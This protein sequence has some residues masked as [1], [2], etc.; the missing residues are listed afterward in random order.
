MKSRLIKIAIIIIHHLQ[1]YIQISIIRT[2][3]TQNLDTIKLKLR[4]KFSKFRIRLSE[5]KTLIRGTE[6]TTDKVISKSIISIPINSHIPD[7]IFTIDLIPFQ[8]VRPRPIVLLTKGYTLQI[9]LQFGCQHDARHDHGQEQD[10]GVHDARRGGVLARRTTRAAKAHCCRT[11]AA[12]QGAHRHDDTHAAKAKKKDGLQN[13][14]ICYLLYLICDSSCLKGHVT[15]IE[16]M[17]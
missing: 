5:F 1:I 6:T 8:F 14:V 9:I 12:G 3:P 7:R 10:D 11:A 16:I 4:L 15:D 17:G 2:N 13:H